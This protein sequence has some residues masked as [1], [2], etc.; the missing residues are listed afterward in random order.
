[1]VLHAHL[2]FVREPE[3]ERFLEENWYFEALTETYLPLLMN[4]ETLIRDQVDFRVA[5]TLTPPLVSMFDDEL[6]RT[7]FETRLDSLIELAEKELDRHRRDPEFYDLARFYLD[8]FVAQRDFYRQRCGRDITSAFRRLQDVGHIE[9]L[10]SAA[11]HGFLPVVRHVPSSV[12]AQVRIGVDH[13]EHSFGRSPE[14]IWLPECGFYPGLDDVLAESGL[15]YF[16]VESHAL[17]HGSPRP[18]YGVYAPVVCPSGVAAFARDPECAKQVWSVEE[19]FPG[20]PDYREFYRDVGFDSHLDYVEPYIGPDGVRIQTGIKYHRVTGETDRKEP[21][22]RERA[23]QQAAEHADT[24]LAWRQSQMEWVAGQTDIRPVVLAPYDAELFGHWWFEGPEWLNF[25]LRRIASDQQ[26]ILTATP[27]EYLAESGD[28]QVSVPAESSWGEG[29]YNHVWVNEENDWMIPELLGAAETMTDLATVHRGAEGIR[30]RALNQAVRE[31]LLA[32][33]SDWAFIVKNRTAVEYATRRVREHLGNFHELATELQSGGFDEERS[34]ILATEHLG[35]MEKK[36]S[37][38]PNVDFE[39]FV[40]DFPR[41]SYALPTEVRHVAFITAEAAPYVKVGGLADVAGALPAALAQQ[42]TRITVILPAYQS[43]Q[44]DEHSI[45]PLKGGLH[46]DVG[47]R[48]IEFGLLEAAS[49]SEGVRVILIGQDEYFAREGVYTDPSSGDGYADNA[50]RFVFFT[51]AALETLRELGEPVEI[52]H[53]HDHHT[54]LAPAYLKL[55]YRQDP[56]LGRASSVYTLHNLGYQGAYG[57][58]V[59]DLTGFGRDQFFA[60]SPFEHNGHVNFM[61]VGVSFADRVNTVSQNYAREICT[62]NELGAGLGEVLR[63]RG[64]DFQGIL[65]G[66]DVNEWNPAADPALPTAYSVDDMAGKLDAKRLLFELTSLDPARIDAPLVGMITRLV[67]QKGLDLVRD[68]FD[69]MLATGISLVV[70]G[71]GLPRYEAF[72]REAAKRFPGQIA[73]LIKFDNNLAHLIEAGADMFLM[74]SLYEPCGLNQMY[75]LRY[76]TVPIVRATGGLA[77]TVSDDDATV[78]RGVGFSFADYMSEALVDAVERTVRAYHDPE[79]WTQLR[80]RGMRQDHSWRASARKYQELYQ[81]ARL[82]RS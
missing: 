76:G 54:A 4:F 60:G 15:R 17:L 34:D 39:V 45:T 50:E 48:S 9:I 19:G 27:A 69:R 53:C 22:V 56:I 75:S 71:T 73:A 59:L 23:L 28:L 81:E 30:G 46:V 67:D 62:S 55:R 6:L 74:P 16:V 40:E 33:S 8:R 21:Y 31:L 43:I 78:G 82:A 64:R 7:R 52:V 70:L 66:I 20:A 63:A 25:L 79:R 12:R 5:M 1:M 68:A 77:D 57:P 36:H 10:A 24:F 2:P 32:Q 11:T 18:R 14:G 49:P 42:S 61:K 44:W 65:N 51:L 26:T 72:F 47:D 29:G 37:L 80:A 35:T 13:Y 41:P 38:F 3:H 58:E